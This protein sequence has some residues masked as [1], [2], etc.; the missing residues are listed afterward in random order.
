M[1]QSCQRS[2]VQAAPIVIPVIVRYPISLLYPQAENRIR[3]YE[4]DL[5]ILQLV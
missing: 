3:N 5:A 2:I 1:F 4:F